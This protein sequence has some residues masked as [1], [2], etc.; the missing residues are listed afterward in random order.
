[1]KKK[2]LWIKWEINMENQ[3]KKLEFKLKDMKI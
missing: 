1:M 2:K 3:K